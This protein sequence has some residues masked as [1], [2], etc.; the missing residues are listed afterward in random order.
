[1]REKQARIL[2]TSWT[3]VGCAMEIIAPLVYV[4]LWDSKLS[5]QILMALGL[6][7]VTLRIILA[8]G[9]YLASVNMERNAGTEATT[10]VKFNTR[11]AK[12]SILAVFILMAVNMMFI[13]V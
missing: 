10:F 13:H 7:M 11:Q 3:F 2:L 9:I 5:Y 8:G 6:I 1:M 12:W 4:Y